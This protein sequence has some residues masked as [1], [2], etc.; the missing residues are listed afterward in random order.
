MTITHGDIDEVR[1]SAID[2]ILARRSGCQKP[3]DSGLPM[4]RSLTCWVWWDK[5]RHADLALW[6]NCLFAAANAEAAD[7]TGTATRIYVRLGGLLKSS[8]SRRDRARMKR[9]R[10]APKPEPEL[11][12]VV[13]IMGALN[14]ASEAMK[15]KR[16]RGK[17]K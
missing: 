14:E 12:D 5:Q 11:I 4:P 17:Q 8:L 6:Q 7:V 15:P 10:G 13:G 16:K 3:N 2:E 1:A 9:E